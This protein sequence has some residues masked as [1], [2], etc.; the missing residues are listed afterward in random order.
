MSAENKTAS[1]VLPENISVLLKALEK[2]GNHG[3][4]VKLS[5][6][7]R[8]GERP[9]VFDLDDKKLARF[10]D[11]A[12]RVGLSC[13]TVREKDAAAAHVL[14]R[15]SETDTVKHTLEKVGC[16]EVVMQGDIPEAEEGNRPNVGRAALR[17]L[18][19]EPRG[20]ILN[21]RSTRTISRHFRSRAR[22]DACARD[23]IMTKGKT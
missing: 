17:H 12:Q 21:A 4:R 15:A 3:E 7:L 18:K 16:A 10:L 5:S 2:N 11:E 9:V 20:S 6:I 19:S 1:A 14:C 13:V 23:N 22:H 8:G